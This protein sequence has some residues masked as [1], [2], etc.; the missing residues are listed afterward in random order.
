MAGE[1]CI[2]YCDR[3]RNVAPPG[4]DSGA[5]D[6]GL[7]IVRC[8]AQ[9]SVQQRQASGIVARPASNQRQAVERSLIRGIRR[10]PGAVE[11]L[12]RAEVASP[13]GLIGRCLRA[14]GATWQAEQC[15]GAKRRE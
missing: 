13:P 6:R 8:D 9:Q 2:E 15:D 7:D 10:Q 1:D 12:R 3:C 5:I 11:L 14:Q 4:K